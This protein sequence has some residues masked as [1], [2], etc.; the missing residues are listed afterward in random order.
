VLLAILLGLGVPAAA[1]DTVV[2]EFGSSMKYLANS[3]DPGFGLAW[4]GEG[5]DDAAWPGGAYGVGY[6]IAPPGAQAL[7]RTTVPAGA[8]SV[9]TRARFTIADPSEVARMFLGADYDD[10]FVAWINGVEVFRSASM[11]A[12]GPL[13]N[14]NSALHESS[15]GTSP[16]YGT[17]QDISARALAAVHVGVNVLAVGVWNSGAPSSTDL[18]L[19]PRLSFT[20]GISLTRGPYLQSG[21]PTGVVVRWRTDVPTDSRVRYGP[22]PDDL[23]SSADDAALTTEHA[24]T[25]SGLTPDTRYVY[26]VGTTART[27]AGGDAGH[28]FFTAP[29]AG[30]SIPTRVWVLGD[31]GTAD[32][33]ARAVRDA[34]R[35]FAAGGRTNL[36]LMLGDNAYPDGTDTQYQAA[37]FDI[38][39]EMLRQ[40]VVWPTLGNHDGITADSA[41]QSGPYYDIF[42]L[43]RNG[44]AGGLP[45]GTEAYYSF[46]YGNIHLI[47]LESNETNRSPSG[48]MLTWLQ[49]DLL[50]T[51]QEWVIAFWHHP[52][53]S[54]G[55][56]DSD[57]ETE[58]VEMRQNAL[59][60]LEQGGVD[61]VLAGH[62][63]SYERSFLIDGHYGPSSSF[64]E[65]MKKDGGDGRSDG[66]GAYAK[67]T[68]GPAP[69]EGAVY[70][71]AGS[72]GQTSGGTLDHPAMYLSLNV[73][74]S[75][76][77]D[78]DGNRL[79]ARF[80]DAGGARRDYFTLVKNPAPPPIADFT[81][82]PTSGT[83]PL[84]VQ[85]TDRS[86]NG[87]TAWA[88]D[89]DG[90][91]SI[92]SGAQNPAHV[93]DVLGLYSV[94]LT[95][96]GA[97]GADSRLREAYICAL[98]ADG[99]GDADG[100]DIPDG[101]DRCPCVVNP[102]QEDA[103]GDGAGDACDAD[104][105]NDGVADGLD[106]APLAP[107]VCAPPE[108]I[109]DT[110]RLEGRGVATLRW[111][112]SR[113]GLTSNIYR[114]S[115]APTG[116]RVRNETCFDSEEPAEQTSDA[117]NPEVGFA[118][119]YLVSARNACG[120]SPAGSDSQGKPI[121]P[122]APCAGAGRDSDQDGRPDVEDNCP[123]APDASQI[124]GD[125]DTLGDACDNC[126]ES[127]NLQ[128]LDS[129]ADAAGDACDNCPVV[130]NTDQRD[131]D[132]DAAGDACDA[133]DD[134]DGVADALDCAPLDAGASAPLGPVG[135]SLRL[136]PDPA[137]ITWD[138]DT[139]TILWNVYRGQSGGGSPFAYD[140]AC[141]EARSSDAAAHDPGTPAA[142][143]YLYYLVSGLNACGE[144][145][146][147]SSS[148]GAPR[149]NPEPCP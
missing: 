49:E 40:A 50:S 69:H 84:A 52:P 92:D 9:Y 132:L 27:L 129:D 48:A 64:T 116:P 30:T 117:E 75:L 125:G 70:V 106:C 44:E 91:G 107:G 24:V 12:L 61:L 31:S 6:E 124:D 120:E 22:S 119:Y 136:G 102:N 145:G 20:G 47:C 118:F 82:E 122:A 7:L 15:N 1:A 77:L 97:G 79:D 67:P 130:A 87:P 14:T 3:A 4:T 17:L 39:P 85:F 148:D 81:A 62:S 25:L 45:S 80:L 139:S 83:A 74:G 93:Y 140:H 90:D 110:L 133:D 76:V 42:T 21:S 143:A 141:L 135:D 36:W 113:G 23:A 11:P 66:Q 104:D 26:A 121:V 73:L 71:V 18:V 108:P 144:G 149:P 53:Y 43:P 2:V 147:G 131:T 114:G 134:N 19:V 127:S 95:A 51:R 16:N 142:G 57:T 105:D 58:L 111:S 8:Y 126:P 72:S 138:P 123:L 28:A 41:T 32:A 55:S 63:H 101:V 96:T 100:D 109:G 13:W 112:R 10:G 33:S 88:W 5:F 137:S 56:H 128:Q 115:L 54:K 29:P 98:S 46:D 86:V 65:A 99:L 89:F 35:A 37:V 68:S 34:Y 78:V 59:P 146:L 38:F 103:D 94:R 60:I